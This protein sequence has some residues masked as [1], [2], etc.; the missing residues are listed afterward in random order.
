MTKNTTNTKRNPKKSNQWEKTPKTQPREVFHQVR[1]KDFD[2][3]LKVLFPDS[4]LSWPS[5]VTVRNT[6][7]GFF[8]PWF[9]WNISW[10]RGR[11]NKNYPAEK[12][13]T[14]SRR[15]NISL[16]VWTQRHLTS[17]CWERSEEESTFPPF[18]TVYRVMVTTERWTW[19]PDLC[20]QEQEGPTT[21]PPSGW[22][23]NDDTGSDS[24][25]NT[26]LT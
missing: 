23:Q 19:W 17:F 16:S 21:V 20:Q 13:K 8:S 14:G 9:Y 1:N 25:Q 26:N 12:Q 24:S 10:P 4:G 3:V 7:D 11:V 6:K 15:F 22:E 2:K 18:A 5:D